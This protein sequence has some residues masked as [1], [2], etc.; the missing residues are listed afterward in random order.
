MFV[1]KPISVSMPVHTYIE[2]YSIFYRMVLI[3]LE[4]MP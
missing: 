2:P 1:Q 4:P 3:T